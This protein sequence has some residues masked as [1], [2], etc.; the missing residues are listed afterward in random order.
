M[1]GLA[2]CNSTPPEGCAQE[3]Q[4]LLDSDGDVYRCIA[5][6]DCPRTSRLTLC[7]SDADVLDPCIRCL[8]TECVRVFPEVC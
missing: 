8:E 2:G 7:V 1:A 6:E 5:S 4:K 3:P